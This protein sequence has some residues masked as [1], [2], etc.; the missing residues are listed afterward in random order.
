MCE[1]CNRLWREHD[2]AT[3]KSFRLEQRLRR[4][5]LCHDDHLAKALTA[6]LTYVAQDTA[7]TRQAL[8]DHQSQAHP[9]TSAA[10]S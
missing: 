1:E 8:A 5:E 2:E 3:Q 6:K 9:H 7:R 10:G 4:A